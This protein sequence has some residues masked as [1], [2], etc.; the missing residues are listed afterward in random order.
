VDLAS[1]LRSE[2]VRPLVTVIAP[3]AVAAAPYFVQARRLAPGLRAY[4]EAHRTVGFLTAALAVLAAGLILESV[5]SL[6]EA[7][8]IDRW[9][10]KRYPALFE[11][12]YNYLRLTFVPEPVGQRYLRTVTLHL[13]FEIAMMPALLFALVGL[14]WV[15]GDLGVLS[16]KGVSVIS[17]IMAAFIFY[18]AWESFN[19]ALVLAK[20]RFALLTQ[21]NTPF[22][23]G[24]SG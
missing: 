9:L 21:R 19:S 17:L 10:A 16:S 8:V 12:W 15:N 18:F 2:V 22:P 14:N 3:G 1:G 20:T 11:D 7:K 13:K 24:L 6:W 5:G 23:T 4:L